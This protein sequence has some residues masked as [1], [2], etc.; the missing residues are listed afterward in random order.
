MKILNLGL[1]VLGLTCAKAA[2]SAGL[3]ACNEVSEPLSVAYAGFESGI[4]VTHGWTSVAPYSCSQL[5]TSFSNTRYYV[6]ASSSSGQE[7]GANHPFCVNQNAGFNIPYA[8]NTS[9]CTSRSFFSVWVPDMITGK[10]PDHYTVV[11]GP[12][13]LGAVNVSLNHPRA[14]R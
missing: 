12:N 8:D 11:L 1:L 3:Y 13:L 6:Y 5:T 9:A 10:F 4:W 14:E 7:W 2:F